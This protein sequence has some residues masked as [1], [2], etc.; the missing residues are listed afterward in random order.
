MKNIKIAV[1]VL[2]PPGSGKD[3]EAAFIV[4]EY[5]LYQFKTSRFLIEA[6]E[7]G[8]GDPE[9][10][11]ERKI[12]ESGH[13]NTPSWVFGIVEKKTREVASN[14]QGVCYSGS[15]RTKYEVEHLNPLLEELYGKE[16][17]I[18]IY[19]NVTDEVVVWRNT[20]R[21]MCEKCLT[22]VVYSKETEDMKIC[23]VCGGNLI[24]RSLDNP[25]IIK[26]R[27]DVFRQDTGPV[28]DYYRSR[29]ML[30]EVDGKPR[31]EE[32]FVEVKKIIDGHI[33]KIK[34]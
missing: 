28:I 3:T 23:P 27:L 20:R 31:P 26:K 13:L 14:G 33:N 9:I 32:V 30:Y 34:S 7:T 12:L 22:P 6:F 4:K 1:S 2:G 18:P 19:L 16:N 11:K 10:E 25:E 21:K 5:G 24:V 29:G 8:K 17:I 15:P